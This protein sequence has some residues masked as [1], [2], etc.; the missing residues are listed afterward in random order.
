MGTSLSRNRYDI[1]A[2][3]SEFFRLHHRR[4]PYVLVRIIFAIPPRQRGAQQIIVMA[5]TCSLSLSL[6][7]SRLLSIKST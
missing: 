4:H 7:T 2:S 5:Q 1:F 6:Y 3:G